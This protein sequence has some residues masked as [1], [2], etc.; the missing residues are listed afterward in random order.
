[1]LDRLQ[2]TAVEDSAPCAP[3]VCRLDSES[4]TDVIDA[5]SSDSARLILAELHEEPRPVSAL[6]DELGVSIPSIEYHIENLLEAGIVREVDTIYSE[7]GKEMSVYGPADDPLVFV[8]DDEGADLARF[9][10][11]R[12]S[13]AVVA[14]AV[15]SLA[16]QW[17][18]TEFLPALGGEAAFRTDSPPRVGRNWV[19]SHWTARLTTAMPTTAAPTPETTNLARST[20]SS[21]PTNTS[22]SSSGPYTDISLPFSE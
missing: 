21:S 7:K 11:S 17:L 20:P 16:V 9:V 13:A 18:V 3:R 6:A 22:G 19:T 14:V 5:I 1:M 2:S 12:V 4:A 8:G 10:V 15:V